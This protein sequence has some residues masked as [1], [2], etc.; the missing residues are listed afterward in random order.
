MAR[1]QRA[2]PGALAHRHPAPPPPPPGEAPSL[3]LGET[4]ESGAGPS[5]ELC[6]YPMLGETKTEALLISLISLLWELGKFPS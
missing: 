5:A 4:G 3:R 2:R 6:F 1:G